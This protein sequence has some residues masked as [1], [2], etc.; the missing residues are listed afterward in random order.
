MGAYGYSCSEHNGLH[1]NE[2]EFIAEVVNPDTLKSV[3]IGERGELVLTNLGL[4]DIHLFAIGLE[5]L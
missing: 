5:I 1:V 3:E 4:M 2:S